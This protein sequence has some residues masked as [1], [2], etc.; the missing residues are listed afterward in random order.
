[1]NWG[2][3]LVQRVWTIERSRMAQLERVEN[4][5]SEL[6]Q[7]QGPKGIRTVLS[8]IYLMPRPTVEFIIDSAIARLDLS[9]DDPDLE[10][11]GD[12][13]EDRNEY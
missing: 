1:M 6:E 10:D 5:K 4:A 11:D 8:L 7:L 12:R 13:E 2:R 3:H 9:D